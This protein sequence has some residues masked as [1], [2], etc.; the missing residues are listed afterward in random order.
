MPVSVARCQVGYQSQCAMMEP[1]GG[2]DKALHFS[3]G[4]R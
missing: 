2:I 3:K 1:V 4:T